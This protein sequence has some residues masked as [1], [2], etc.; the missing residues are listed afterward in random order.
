M[1][2]TTVIQRSSDDAKAEKA[3]GLQLPFD[4]VLVLATLGLAICSL[5]T[6]GAATGNDIPGSPDYFVIRQLI[7]FVVGAN[8][9]LLNRRR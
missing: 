9:A 4:L 7:Y 5:L 2:A 3:I 8:H 1:S 6:I